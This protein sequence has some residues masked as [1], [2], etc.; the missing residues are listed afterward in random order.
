[1]RLGNR[2][3]HENNRGQDDMISKYATETKEYKE[4]REAR[5]GERSPYHPG[6]H[7]DDLWQ[8]GYQ[9]SFLSGNQPP[10]PYYG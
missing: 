10:I 4:G 7:K 3:Q 5:F 1:M 9:E 2:V 6:T 8:A